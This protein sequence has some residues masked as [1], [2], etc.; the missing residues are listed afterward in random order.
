MVLF[1]TGTLTTLVGFWKYS[2]QFYSQKISTLV[3]KFY[4]S[5]KHSL[6]LNNVIRSKK[7]IIK[8][9]TRTVLAMQKEP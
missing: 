4:P 2:K 9:Y 3:G 8:V 6:L 5:K 7:R 1:P